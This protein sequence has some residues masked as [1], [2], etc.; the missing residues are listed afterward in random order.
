[1]QFWYYCQIFGLAYEA[2]KQVSAFAMPL[3]I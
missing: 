1:M 3:Q 2:I